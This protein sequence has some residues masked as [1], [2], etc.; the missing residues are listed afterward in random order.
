M[1]LLLYKDASEREIKWLVN[2]TLA[3][4]PAAWIHNATVPGTISVIADERICK[5]LKDEINQSSIRCIDIIEDKIKRNAIRGVSKRL[6]MNQLRVVVQASSQMEIISHAKDILSILGDEQE[7]Y[8]SEPEKEVRHE[9]LGVS[10][11]AVEDYLLRLAKKPS[12][13]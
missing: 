4:S 11:E 10:K 3:I 12:I 8:S 5:N 7:S 2:N 9:E 1:Y 6:A 13:H